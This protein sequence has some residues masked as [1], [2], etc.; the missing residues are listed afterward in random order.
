MPAARSRSHSDTTP[1]LCPHHSLWFPPPLLTILTLLRHPQDIPPTLPSTLL[2]PPPTRLMLSTAYHAYSCVV[3]SQHASNT[4]LTMASSTLT[5][6]ML[7]RSRRHSD[8]TP[9]P[10]PSPLPLPWRPQPS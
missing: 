4:A 8:A 10:K 7:T 9:P 5:L 6:R 1:Q 3:P 2:P